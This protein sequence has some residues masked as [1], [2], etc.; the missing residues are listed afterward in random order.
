MAKNIYGFGESKFN[1]LTI[2]FL[3]KYGIKEPINAISALIITYFANKLNTDNITN[4]KKELTWTKN[5]ILLNGLTS[6]FMHT[7]LAKSGLSKNIAHLDITSM[8]AA[9]Y[10][11][12]SIFYPKLKVENSLLVLFIHGFINIDKHKKLLEFFFGIGWILIVIKIYCNLKTKKE[13]KKLYNTVILGLLGSFLQIVDQIDP[14]K[15]PKLIF[16][17]KSIPFHGLWHF[18]AGY[19]VTKQLEIIKN[20]Y[21]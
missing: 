9:I 15:I 10:S 14:N 16:L 5:Y 11:T 1:T 19:A 4:K 7:T 13:R 17:R 21:N 3:K 20:I 12:L 6:C 18:L 8:L 2:N